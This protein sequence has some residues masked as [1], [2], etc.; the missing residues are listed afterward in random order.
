[1]G[2]FGY[3]QQVMRILSKSGMGLIFLMLV[4]CAV[5]EVEE[6]KPVENVKHDALVGRVAMVN[7][8]DAYVLI[9]QYRRIPDDGDTIF[10]GQSEGGERY[11]LRLSGQH[12]GQFVAADLVDAGAK[13]VIGDAIFM[14]YLTASDEAPANTEEKKPEAEKDDKV[15]EEKE[16]EV[17]TEAEESKK[18]DA[19]KD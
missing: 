3:F 2:W 6:S 14:R 16:P 11:S 7:K 5:K 13:V 4:G 19:K 8:K 10:Y 18:A 9:E 12:Q 15:D 17:E 1:M